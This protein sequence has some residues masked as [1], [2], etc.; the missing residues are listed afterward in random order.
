MNEAELVLR[1]LSG[2][3]SL[4]AQIVSRYS[5]CVW[6]VCSSYVKNPSDCEDVTQE[7]FVQC[8]RRLDTLRNPRALGGWLCQLARRHA[9][10]WLRTTARREQRLTRYGATEAMSM[11]E[12]TGAAQ[13]ELHE[14]IRNAID[15][16][17]ETYQEALLLRYA[18]RWFGRPVVSSPVAV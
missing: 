18:D 8:Y 13:E 11:T 12:N 9:L 4:F 5:G 14:A 10:M 15:M 7:V 3:E 6:A 1:I 2:E 17:P 16:L